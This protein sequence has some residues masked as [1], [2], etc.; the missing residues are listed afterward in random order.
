[1]ESLERGQL[2][3]II[4]LENR[5]TRNTFVSSFTL[6]NYAYVWDYQF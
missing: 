4:Q 3:T 2:Y 5:V 6:N 1:M